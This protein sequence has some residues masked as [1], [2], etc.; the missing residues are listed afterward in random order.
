LHFQEKRER[1]KVLCLISE[2]KNGFEKERGTGYLSQQKKGEGNVHL[3]SIGGKNQG[4]ECQGEERECPIYGKKSKSYLLRRGEGPVDAGLQREEK[5]RYP[6]TQRKKEKRVSH[7]SEKEVDD[8]D[9][10]RGEGGSSF[11]LEEKK[12]EGRLGAKKKVGGGISPC[13]LSLQGR[14]EKKK[15]REGTQYAIDPSPDQKG[16]ARAIRGNNGKREKRKGRVFY[17]KKGKKKRERKGDGKLSHNRKEEEVPLEWKKKKGKEGSRSFL[18]SWEK[19]K[20]SFLNKE[21]KDPER[22]GLQHCQRRKRRERKGEELL[23][24]GHERRIFEN[25]FVLKE[26]E[27]KGEKKKKGAEK[28]KN[29]RNG[30]A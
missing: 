10:P 13:H 6:L 27:P 3:L 5:S 24:P 12:R 1:E 23:L 15:R 22:G 30:V 20:L 21:M 26:R 4:H 9:P 8:H 2:E 11:L 7:V 29:C 28:K 16:E 18:C 17:R 19:G 25:P 14:K